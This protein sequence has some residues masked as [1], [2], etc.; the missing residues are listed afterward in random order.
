MSFVTRYASHESPFFVSSGLSGTDGDTLVYVGLVRPT[1]SENLPGVSGYSQDSAGSSISSEFPALSSAL[2]SL[3][4]ETV[5]PLTFEQIRDMIETFVYRAELTSPGGNGAELRKQQKEALAVIDRDKATEGQPNGGLFKGMFKKSRAARQAV[6]DSE[7][8][9][10]RCPHCHWE[11]DEELGYCQGCDRVVALPNGDDDD[12]D[13]D[14]DPYI[15]RG[16][17]DIESDEDEDE[18]EDDDTEDDDDDDDDDDEDDE[19]ADES[20]W[21][22]ED[23]FAE[24]YSAQALGVALPRVPTATLGLDTQLYR[25]VRSGPITEGSTSSIS[26]VGGAGLVPTRR[27]RPTLPSGD[28]DSQDDTEG[29]LAEFIDDDSRRRV[30]ARNEANGGRGGRSPSAANRLQ[31]APDRSQGAASS[32]QNAATIIISSSPAIVPAVRSRRARR[33]ILDEEDDEI[34]SSVSEEFS[35]PS[36]LGGAPNSYNQHRE[37]S[38]ISDDEEQLLD[39][40]TPLG[41]TTAS[42]NEDDQHSRRST[43]AQQGSTADHGPRSVTSGPG[44]VFSVPEEDEESD[45]RRFGDDDSSEDED[46]DEDED[47]DVSMGGHDR[48]SR[49]SASGSARPPANSARRT[50]NRGGNRMRPVEIPDSDTDSDVVVRS[51]RGTRP[52]AS[53]VGGRN[54]QRNSGTT[55]RS[56]SMRTRFNPRLQGLLS[57]H[58]QLRERIQ[59]DSLGRFSLDFARSVT[60]VVQRQHTGES[61]RSSTPVQRQHTGES[62]RSSTPV[63]RQHTGGAGRAPT[64]LRLTERSFQQSLSPPNALTSPSPVDPSPISSPSS[65]SPL[66]SPRQGSNKTVPLNEHEG[67]SS[68]AVLSNPPPGPPGPPRTGPV[69]FAPSPQRVRNRNSRHQLRGSSSRVGLRASSITPTP[70]G[71]L[72]SPLSGLARRQSQMPGVPGRTLSAG[73]PPARLITLDDVRARGEAVRQQRVS[74]EGPS[75]SAQLGRRSSRRELNAVASQGQSQSQLTSGISRMTTR[76]GPSDSSGGRIGV[77]IA[78]GPVSQSSGGP[79]W[80]FGGP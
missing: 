44:S 13:D 32:V 16:L 80:T 20:G 75:S 21:Q 34:Q 62:R 47:G 45:S 6:R 11:V 42:E 31:N 73:A 14:D 78:N 72:T 3:A 43:S 51:R 37:I 70:A 60:P 58:H 22:D 61:R 52:P 5:N 26:Q 29:S 4:T 27:R 56:A 10:L 2:V 65:F 39:G 59:Y 57:D 7:D 41:G 8:A 24:E 64:P 12:E 35:R 67:R 17:D 63:Q 40:Y 66:Q 79:M 55:S 18:D 15:S 36:T 71:L 48:T 33:T 69:A 76:A 19:D 49:R 46:E 30:R 54:S 1:R 68:R 74:S 50:R 28:P 23:E 77:A 25:P 53:M 38:L 9:V